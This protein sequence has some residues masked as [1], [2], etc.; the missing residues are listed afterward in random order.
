MP[1]RK[2]KLDQYGDP[3]LEEDH[4]YWHH[5]ERRLRKWCQG[6]TGGTF[7]GEHPQL[8]KPGKPRGLQS[9]GRGKPF[10]PKISEIRGF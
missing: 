7:S 8:K 9:L 4:D 2:K 10:T 6:G 3:S 1:K 5:S